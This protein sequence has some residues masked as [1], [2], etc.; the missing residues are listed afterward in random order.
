MT[1]RILLVD[2]H[3]VM[4]DG[5]CT[6]MMDQP[7]ID[8]VGIAR[9]GWE[10]I[11]KADELKPDMVII[12]IGMPKLNGIEAARKI[13]DQFP[14]INIIALSMHP[15]KRYITAMLRAGAAGYLMKSCDIEELL[16]AVK[17]VQDGKSYIS[18]NMAGITTNEC[19]GSDNSAFSVLSDRE[20]EVLQYMSEGKSTKA[21]AQLLNVSLTTAETH[22]RRLMNK[23]N[24]HNIAELTKY[25]IREGMT[26]LYT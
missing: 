16:R 2:D 12:D 7:D 18:P 24:I 5:L 13:K 20:R 26:S 22:R 23:L 8:V 19:V 11:D 1:T 14:A 17:T 4:L 10:A 3:K 6:L 15:N 25:A 21:I 9:D